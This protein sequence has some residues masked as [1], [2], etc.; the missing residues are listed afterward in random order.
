MTSYNQAIVEFAQAGLAA[1]EERAS[2]ANVIK[3][4]AAESHF[5]CS[6]MASAL[7]VRQFSKLIA[8]DLTQWIRD[9]RSLGAGAQLPSLLE[10]IDDQYRAAMSN[11]QLGQSL[12]LFLSELEEN[13]WIV[14]LDEEVT[15][16]LKLDS[17][18]ENSLVISHEQYESHIKDKNVIKPIT[19]FVRANEQELARVAAK[20]QLLLSQGDKKASLIKHHKAYR[21]FPNNEQPALALLLD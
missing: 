18:G 1:L 5:L 3:T 14:I 12:E 11:R 16:K 7:K 10:R 13:D 17:E 2:K 4:A 19:M 8:K 20:H 21:V 6:W 15:T 9:G